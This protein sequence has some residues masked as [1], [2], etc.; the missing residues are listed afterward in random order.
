VYWK[1]TGKSPKCISS[2]EDRSSLISSSGN[3]T[4]FE[5][6]KSIS[7]ATTMDNHENKLENTPDIAY[8]N[9]KQETEISPEVKQIS[10]YA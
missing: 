6:V 3:R 2:L 10:R 4:A 9:M 8:A 1:L 7:S 5:I